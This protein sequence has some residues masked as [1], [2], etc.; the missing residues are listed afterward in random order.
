MGRSIGSFLL[1]GFV[2]NRLVCVQR[3]QDIFKRLKK[4]NQNDVL[5]SSEVA[6]S[7]CVRLD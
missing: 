4:V 7:S 6:T 1:S 5:P 3:L 2:S